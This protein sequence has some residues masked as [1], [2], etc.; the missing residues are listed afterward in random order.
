MSRASEIIARGDAE[1]ILS[2]ALGA[3]F[4]AEEGRFCECAEPS[5]HGW[6]LMCGE[7]LLENQGQIERLTARIREPHPFEPSD[8]SDAA[9]WLGMCGI[10]SM[11]EDDPRHV[12]GP[13]SDAGTPR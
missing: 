7:C 2:M 13:A 11:W 9:R 1:E 6:D 10:C 5:L 4:A 8:R 12:P 3:R